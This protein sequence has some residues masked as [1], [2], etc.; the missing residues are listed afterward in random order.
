M[1]DMKE[2]RTIESLHNHPESYI[3]VKSFPE[4]DYVLIHRN[5]KFMPWIAAWAY[6]EEREC[7]GQGH[8]FEEFIDAV[9][10]IDNKL[11]TIPYDRMS[12]IAS[13]LMD[14]AR[15]SDDIDDTL[16]DYDVELD[17]KEREYFGLDNEEEDDAYA[18]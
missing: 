12:E 13:R 17:K 4:I 10:Y 18:E 7:W 9:R 16:Y 6:N 15:E 2:I 5:T 3:V 1:E 11:R 14:F 8:Y